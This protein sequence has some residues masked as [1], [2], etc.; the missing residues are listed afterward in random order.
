MSKPSWL[1][2]QFRDAGA[3]THLLIEEGGKTYTVPNT[4]SRPL[5]QGWRGWIDVMRRWL[6]PAAP[7]HVRHSGETHEQVV[8]RILEQWGDVVVIIDI[9]LVEQTT[10]QL[11]D[12]IETLRVSVA[13]MPDGLR[14]RVHSQHN[15]GADE[16]AFRQAS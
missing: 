4:R 2:A 16:P 15:P 11:G 3:E 12:S 9:Q 6:L 14:A 10:C 5:R 7:A 8:K 13:A 1:E